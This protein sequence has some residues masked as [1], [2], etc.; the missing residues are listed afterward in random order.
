MTFV[1]RF[2]Y[3]RVFTYYMRNR[4]KESF[5]AFTDGMCEAFIEEIHSPLRMPDIIKEWNKYGFLSE[6]KLTK[7]LSK[8]N[9]IEMQ[10]YFRYG[11]PR[12][13]LAERYHTSYQR[14]YTHTQ[15]L[16]NL[17]KVEERYS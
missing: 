6:R 3:F 13:V 16:P 7:H 15:Y 14:V 17:L 11:I 4:F 8:E 2:I 10:N 1:D 5:D 9:I 12:L